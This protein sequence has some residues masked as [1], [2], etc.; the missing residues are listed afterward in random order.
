MGYGT[1]GNLGFVS[2]PLAYLQCALEKAMEFGGQ[3]ALCL[4]GVICLLYLSLNG[5]FANDG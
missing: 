3:W 4:G 1:M 2:Y 5:S